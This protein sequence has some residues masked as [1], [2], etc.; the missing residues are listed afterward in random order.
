MK[1]LYVIAMAAFV[2]GSCSLRPAQ[3]PL[4]AE[5]AVAQPVKISG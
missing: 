3:S 2:A 1:W 4:L 5:P